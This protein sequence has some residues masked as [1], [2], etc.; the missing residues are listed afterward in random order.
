[1]NQPDRPNKF[2]LAQ[3][4]AQRLKE[5]FPELIIGEMQD[6]GIED[7]FIEVVYP[8]DE[9]EEMK[10][11]Y[12]AAKLSG[13]YLDNYSTLVTPLSGSNQTEEQ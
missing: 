13:E 11:R 2:K 9:F 12:E 6:D 3:E 5:K 7:V 10:I 1:M 8:N 4:M